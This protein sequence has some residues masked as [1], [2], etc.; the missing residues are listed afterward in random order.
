[1]G[2]FLKKN[3]ELHHQPHISITENYSKVTAIIIISTKPNNLKT[4]QVNA[5]YSRFYIHYSFIWLG[6]HIL[7]DSQCNETIPESILVDV[8]EG[9][10]ITCNSF[11]VLKMCRNFAL[12]K[13][14]TKLDT[15]CLKCFKF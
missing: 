1:M 8:S 4:T 7:I 12:L 5:N 6:T 9:V 3:H 11:L 15:A 10:N 13:K 14:D 2:K